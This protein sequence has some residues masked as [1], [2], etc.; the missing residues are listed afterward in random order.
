MTFE[1]LNETC[2][3]TCYSLQWN[4]DYWSYSKDKKIIK[5]HVLSTVLLKTTKKLRYLIINP[6]SCVVYILLLDNRQK[7]VSKFYKTFYNTL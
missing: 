3:H 4:C 5:Y 6:A 1:T 2:M 7:G